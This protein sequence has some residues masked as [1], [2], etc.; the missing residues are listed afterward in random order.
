MFAFAIR[1]GGGATQAFAAVI[2][3]GGTCL[4][5]G[6][7]LPSF[8][9]PIGGGATNRAGIFVRLNFYTVITRQRCD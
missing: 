5:H 6:G 2:S 7:I 9:P 8:V 3:F 4:R 1:D